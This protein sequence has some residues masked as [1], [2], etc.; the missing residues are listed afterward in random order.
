MGAIMLTEDMLRALWPNGDLKVPGL[1]EGIAAAA[2]AVFPAFALT[3][4][5]MI[6]HAMAQFG[7][8]YGAGQALV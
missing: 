2:P 4:D 5:L 6:A 7:H 1:I 3:N 8:E